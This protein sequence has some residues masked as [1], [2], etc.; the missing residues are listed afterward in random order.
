MAAVAEV[1]AAAVVAAVAVAEAAAEVA[2]VAVAVAAEAEA[3]AEAAVAVAEV[4]VV[5]VVAAVEEAEVVVEVAGRWRRWRWRWRRRN[6]RAPHPVHLVGSGGLGDARHPSRPRRAACTE[7]VARV[8]P[9]RGRECLHRPVLPA[10]LAV[11]RERLVRLNRDPVGARAED[12][13]RA[14]VEH[15]ARPVGEGLVRARLEQRPRQV[16]A[17]VRIEVD[18]GRR[19]RPGAVEVL[20]LDVDALDR[21]RVPGRNREVVGQLVVVLVERRLEVLRARRRS[22]K[23]SYWS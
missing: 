6:G 10:P 18:V 5:A 4:E 16:A 20:A 7:A 21:P 15:E 1:E 11:R 14:E 3:V 12:D 23:L 19:R 8:L 22:P 17:A 2:E 13:G 9:G